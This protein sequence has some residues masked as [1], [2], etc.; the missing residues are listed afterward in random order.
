M[1]FNETIINIIFDAAKG[2]VTIPSREA[3]TGK[4]FNI[5]PRPAR[6]GYEFKG[7]YLDGELVTEE[8]V[9]TATEDIRLVAAWEKAKGTKQ[10]SMLSRQKVAVVVLAVVAVLL[11]GVLL[12]VNHVITIYPLE[13]VYVKD[14]VEYTD[15]YYVKKKNGVYGLYDKKGKAMEVNSDGYFIAVGSGNQY[16]IDPETGE[17]SLYAVVDYGEGELLGFS[18]RI[19]MFPQIT[20]TNTY[21]I[22][23]TNEYGTYLFYRDKSGNV[24]IEGTED[25][26]VS[27]NPELFASLCVSCGYMLTMQK[28]NLSPDYV[29]PRLPDGSVDYSAY[30]LAD[31]YDADGNLTYTP[32]VY[33]ITQANYA[34]DG[35]CTA[36]DVSYT[37]K[38]GDAL[39]SGGGYYV[40]LV[41]REAVY[42]V[43]STIQETVLQ[44][45]EALV[46]PAV[47]YPMS[48]A[49]HAMVQNFWLTAY[50]GNFE[51]EFLDELQR[52]AKIEDEDARKAEMDKFFED[53]EKETEELVSFTYKDLEDRA[54]TMYTSLPYE[55]YTQLMKGYELNDS[56]VSAALSMLYQMEFIACR[57]LGLDDVDWSKF[58]FNGDVF[59]LFFD[60]PVTDSSNNI[61][62]YVSNPLF[63]S[64]KTEDGTY[65]I[66][67]FVSGMVVE[68]DQHYLSFL[69]WE[70]SDWYKQYFFQNNISYIDYLKIQIGDKTYSFTM[71]NELSYIYYDK[72]G[73]MTVVDLEKG[74]LKTA[75][76][77]K[78]VYVDQ[79]GTQHSVKQFDPDSAKLCIRLTDVR[80]PAAAPIYLPYYQY[81]L[82]KDKDGNR[83]LEVKSADGTKQTYVIGTATENYY[84]YRL[85][86]C[87][88]NAIDPTHYDEVYEVMG[89]YA[90]SGSSSNV[91]DYYR[92]TYWAET[93]DS[94]GNYV[95]KKYADVNA[96]DNLILRDSSGKTYNLTLGT[97]NIKI[98]C[99]Q[100]TGGI[101]HENLLDYSITYEYTTDKGTQKTQ[102]VTGVD[103][104]RQVYKA[105]MWY[106]IEGDAD[107]SI[108]EEKYGGLDQFLAT[109]TPN[110]T[111]SYRF[112]DKATLMN[113][114]SALQYGENPNYDLPAVSQKIWAEN[115]SLEAVVRLYEY[116]AT[117]SLITIEVITEYDENGNPISD[118]Q[119][120]EGTFYVLTS[121]CNT[122]LDAL[123]DL[124]TKYPVDPKSSDITI[125]G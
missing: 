39:L 64:P 55:T 125:I 107:L 53:F 46:T 114:E 59:V 77:G 120:G 78:L 94:N 40:Q 87:V 118:P 9:I 106:S 27:Y 97:N 89:S 50:K 25:L 88:P 73:T 84:N 1:N 92:L 30:G 123:N 103:N 10:A 117:K 29:A 15:K 7:W 74:S 90:A 56:N 14:G 86:Y 8:T 99:D 51:E 85:V 24:F 21:S 122:L 116:S 109:A 4:P 76:D 61:V 82:T 98:Y 80:N 11:I 62:G 79:N 115:N 65:Y 95:W 45:I 37:V 43:S 36:S 38:V 20:Q 60:S 57:K 31:I 93:K 113:L 72:D 47:T 16:E 54:N 67:S 124:V 104:F 34:A 119:K 2:T 33:T 102:T 70:R 58:D 41:G 3:E 23:V 22:K 111:I 6:A 101:G 108:F 69:E 42:I 81:L 96:S 66:A 75:S 91:N 121:Y 44:P 19:M 5:L 110:A 112:E 100:F 12:V 63:I 28:L 48:M 32:A 26:M 13:D 49:T 52:I 68:V 18:D 35:T 71:D 17:F 105:L 83:S